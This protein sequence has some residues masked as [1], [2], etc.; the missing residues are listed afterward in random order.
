MSEK[1]PSIITKWSDTEFSGVVWNLLAHPTDHILF[2]ETRDESEKQVR[3]SA[4]D[5]ENQYFLWRE[6]SLE[7]KWWI[8]LAGAS[9]SFV[10][11]TMYNEVQNP[12]RKSLIA[13]DLSTARIAWWRNNF[14]LSEVKDTTVY[15]TDTALGTNFLALNLKDG[16]PLNIQAVYDREENFLLQKPL[17]YAKGSDYF[18]TV[19]LFLKQRFNLAASEIIEYMEIGDFIIISCYSEEKNLAN[20]L[21][22]ITNDG[23][24]VL[25]EKIGEQLKGIGIDTFFILSGYLIFVKNKRALVS[26]KLI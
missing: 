19:A 21:I 4:F 15:G 25:N 6:I 24:V 23:K 10:L 3:F 9:G 18:N 14:A 20:F 1:T 17:Q 11:F 2:V 12:D 16:Q 7:E 8:S 13:L 5:L 26:Y 22:V